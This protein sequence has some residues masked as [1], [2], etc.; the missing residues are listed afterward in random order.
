M[1]ILVHGDK[2][3]NFLVKESNIRKY[4]YANEKHEGNNIDFLRPWFCEL[5]ALYYGLNNYKDNIIGLEQYRRFILSDDEKQPITEI[6]ILEKLKDADVICGYNRYP[7]PGVGSYIYQW[8]IKTGK[9]Y[10]FEVYLEVLKELYGESVYIHFKNF[11][12]GQWHCH[13]NLVIGKKELLENYFN[14]LIDTFTVLKTKLN[15][16]NY[17]RMLEYISEFL[18]G[19]WLTYNNKKIY[20]QPWYNCNRVMESRYNK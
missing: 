7:D 1:K 11:L 5:T 8:P 9:Q 4:Y 17:P 2:D 19:A 15:I 12:Y 3:K 20:W 18:F 13:G 16:Q 6:E 10:Y 14:F